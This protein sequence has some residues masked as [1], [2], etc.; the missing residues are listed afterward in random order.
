M[1]AKDRRA[2]LK[3]GTKRLTRA[4]TRHIRCQIYFVAFFRKDDRLID[5]QEKGTPMNIA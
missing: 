4:R 3:D 5:E 2:F 1:P